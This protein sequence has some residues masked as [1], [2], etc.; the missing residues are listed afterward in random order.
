MR[1]KRSTAPYLRGQRVAEYSRPLAS[2]CKGRARAKSFQWMLHSRPIASPS[3]II[4]Y[5]AAPSALRLT[6]Y[7]DISSTLLSSVAPNDISRYIVLGEVPRSPPLPKADARGQGTSLWQFIDFL[8][9]MP[10]PKLFL[11]KQRRG[12]YTASLLSYCASRLVWILQPLYS[13]PLGSTASLR[14]FG[15][16]V[17]YG[18]SPVSAT[19]CMGSPKVCL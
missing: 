8:G 3:P 1:G 14:H 12:E 5:G 4:L 7:R 11:R 18:V 19:S 10:P 6:T 17:G 9:I 16:L 13:S 15:P 2:P